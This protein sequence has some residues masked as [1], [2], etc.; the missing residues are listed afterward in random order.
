VKQIR[1]IAKPGLSVLR[2]C[3]TIIDSKNISRRNAGVVDARH[4]RQINKPTIGATS[5]QR[6]RLRL[7]WPISATCLVKLTERRGALFDVPGHRFRPHGSAMFSPARAMLVRHR[8]AAKPEDNMI[9]ARQPADRHGVSGSEMGRASGRTAMAGWSMA[10]RVFVVRSELTR[11]RA[12]L[13]NMTAR[14]LADIGVTACDRAM[15]LRNREWTDPDMRPRRAC[16][17]S[18]IALLSCHDNET[19]YAGRSV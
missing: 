1:A 16:P 14:D 8:L 2:F 11:A 13:A 12:I 15:A 10:R 4:G 3:F 17:F 19:N 6:R 18:S 9:E 5:R 7:D